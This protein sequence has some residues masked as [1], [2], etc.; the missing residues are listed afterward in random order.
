M[1]TVCVTLVLTTNMTPASTGM[2][3]ASPICYVV[4]T[5]TQRHPVHGHVAGIS[6]MASCMSILC[7]TSL[8][9]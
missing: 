8:T 5:V 9:C 1:V 6:I 3:V 2:Q 7:V 4:P